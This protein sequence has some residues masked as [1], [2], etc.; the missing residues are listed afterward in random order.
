MSAPRPLRAILALAVTAL[1]TPFGAALVASPARAATCVGVQLAPTDN[2]Q[3]VMNT[4]PSGTVYCFAAG[5]YRLTAPLIPKSG[6]TL[7]GVPGAVLNGSRVLNT[8]SPLGATWVA[9]GQLEQYAPDTAYPCNTFRFGANYDRCAYPESIFLD[10]Q[11]L[12]QVKTLSEVQPGTFY[13][14]YASD[15]VYIGDNPAG[16]VIETAQTQSGISGSGRINNVTVD[17][18]TLEKFASTSKAAPLDSHTGDNWIVRNSEFRLNSGPGLTVSLGAQVSNN[19]I[20]DN[21]RIGITGYGGNLLIEN[22]EV[23]YNDNAGFSGWAAGGSKFYKSVGVTI[24]GNWFHDNT[25]H[26]IWV[27]ISSKDILIEGNTSERNG[28]QGIAAEVDYNVVIR[29]N[30]SL[31]NGCNGIFISATPDVEAYGNTIAGNI[32]GGVVLYQGD[33][34]MGD[35][36][37]HELRNVSTHDNDITMTRG[38]TGLRVGVVAD[39]SSYFTSRNITFTSNTYHL[40]SPLAKAFAWDLTTKTSSQWQASGNDLTSTF[41]MDAPR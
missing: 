22:N 38:V 21:G 5:T 28:C 13:F 39:Q 7:V 8:F 10:N 36:G 15:K 37:P 20:H 16:H 26:G 1:I 25:A 14:D 18:L 12:W 6:D 2:V 11:P 33:R 3:A 23:S 40:V 9:S 17:G 32:K 30:V 27:D 34:G 29:N 4:K 24:R 19:F 35:F 31:D 41:L